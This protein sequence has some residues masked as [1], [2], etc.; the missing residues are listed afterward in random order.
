MGAKILSRPAL[1]LF[2]FFADTVPQVTI[3]GSA[4]AP[5]PTTGEAEPLGKESIGSGGN[6]TSRA[7]GIMGTATV[8]K[9]GGEGGGTT[10][11]RRGTTMGGGG[12]TTGRAVP[13]FEA[14]AMDCGNCYRID[15][16][17]LVG[18]V[19]GDVVLT[20]IIIIVVYF[21][22]RQKNELRSGAEDNKVYMNMPNR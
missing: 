2:L 12:P 13:V 6:T 11:G 5:S 16:G 15:T 4:P 1:L 21:C 17:T 19:T 18:V 8:G 3:L 7:D 14:Q 22:A 9:G 10:T 20:I